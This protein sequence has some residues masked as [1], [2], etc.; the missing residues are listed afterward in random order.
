MPT[1]PAHPAAGTTYRPLE[2]HGSAARH[3]VSFQRGDGA[4]A[5]VT[6]APRLPLLLARA[7]GWRD[8][9][10]RL[11]RGPWRDVLGGGEFEGGERTL[12]SLLERFPMALLEKS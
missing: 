10:V 8:T 11:P 9:T 4:D 12:A 6:V 7:G 2:V 1:Y 3:V 5:V